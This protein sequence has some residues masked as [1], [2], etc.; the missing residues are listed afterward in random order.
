M[1]DT[2]EV[3]PQDTN[4]YVSPIA[5]PLMAGKLY[6][7]TLKLVRKASEAKT[8]R[9]GVPEVIKAIRKGQKGYVEIACI[10]ISF[11]SVVIIAADIFPVEVVAHL[12][13]FC[14]EKG[15]LYSYVP[16]RQA[17]GTACLTKR[18]ASAIMVFE[19]KGDAASYQKYYDVVAK[20]IKNINQYV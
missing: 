13:V 17:L 8:I 7:K 3:Q 15:I 11:I 18:A 16:S 12:P 1:S 19:P 20:G 14:E 9:R 2:E 4:L 6:S 5:D 10:Y